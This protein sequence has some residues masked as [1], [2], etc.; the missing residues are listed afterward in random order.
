MDTSEYR[1][2]WRSLT[3]VLQVQ[4]TV[5][6]LENQITTLA[7]SN[8]SQESDLLQHDSEV[9]QLQTSLQQ[10]HQHLASLHQTHTQLAQRFSVSSLL[11]MLNDAIEQADN[12]SEEV[13][14]CVT[15]ELEEGKSDALK[16]FLA[17]RKL[18]HARAAKR[19]RLTSQPVAVPS[20]S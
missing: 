5:D 3:F 4:Q 14:D 12:Q 15:S 20:R 11:A 2:L 10:H 16:A 18:Y 9:Q 17:S 1:K 13:R 7:A 8:L 19:D 6:T